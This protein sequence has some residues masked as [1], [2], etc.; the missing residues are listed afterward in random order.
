MRSDRRLVAAK[1]LLSALREYERRGSTQALQRLEAAE[2]DLTEHVLEALSRLN[3]DLFD[4][5]VAP[6]VSRRIV[7]RVES[8]VV[9]TIAALQAA[10]AELWSDVGPYRSDEPQA[11]DDDEAGSSPA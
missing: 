6:R 3:S 4:A 9:V 10:H 7:R 8:M 11:Q 1:H 5:G 2:P